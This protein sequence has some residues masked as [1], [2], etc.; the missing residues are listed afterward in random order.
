MCDNQ[1]YENLGAAQSQ[2]AQHKSHPEIC[3]EQ[4][5][6]REDSELL[7]PVVFLNTTPPHRTAKIIICNQDASEVRSQPLW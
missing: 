6:P 2:D 3:V 5:F 4:A 7:S 1:F